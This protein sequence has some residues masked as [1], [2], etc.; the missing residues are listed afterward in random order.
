MDKGPEL[1]AAAFVELVPDLGHP[2]RRQRT[3][4]ALEDPFVESFKGRLRDEY[5]NTEDFA[6]ISQAKPRLRTGN[7]STTTMGPT[8][9][10]VGAAAYAS[11]WRHTNTNHNTHSTWTHK[12]VPLTT[13]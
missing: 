3:G 12:R 10:S 13:K 4:I 5:L 11:H 9:P 7:S 6:D 2:H 1:I 8:K